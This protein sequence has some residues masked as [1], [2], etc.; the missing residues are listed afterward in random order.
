MKSSWKR[1]AGLV[2]A[3]AISV[4]LFV[5]GMS[6]GPSME[7]LKF[8]LPFDAKLGSMALP[9]G[10]YTI[11]V[12]N[13][14]TG[15]VSVTSG[16][17]GVGMVFPQSFASQQDQTEKPTLVCVRHDGNVAVRALK[18]PNVGTYYFPLPKE[19]KLIS[20]KQPELIETVS[21]EVAGQ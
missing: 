18:L 8:N 6:A 15:A 10:D 5:P 14:G 3:V 20:A 1:I 17:Q 4:G 19:L 12:S 16:L 11:S 2:C 7:R 9:K 21:V 13:H